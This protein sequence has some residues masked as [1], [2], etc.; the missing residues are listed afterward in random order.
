MPHE[1]HKMK[2]ILGLSSFLGLTALSVYSAQHL[3]SR[4][5]RVE[6]YEV[7]PDVLATPKYGANGSLCEIAI[8]KRHVQ[9]DVVD[10]GATIPHEVT[11]QIIDELAPPF[12]RGKRTGA[13]GKFD[14][15]MI[16]GTSGVTVLDYENVTGQIFRETSGSGDTAIILRW[17]N[18]CGSLQK[19]GSIP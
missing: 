11:L 14:Y 6:S 15:E 8:E 10:L 4:Y 12:K 13:L 7:R 5:T 17:K 19:R 1:G 2:W 16:S 3:Q 9:R 18:A